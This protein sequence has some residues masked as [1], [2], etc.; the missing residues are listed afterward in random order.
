MKGRTSGKLTTARGH[1]GRT[2]G[3]DDIANLVNEVADRGMA[4]LEK[5]TKQLGDH[6]GGAL[7]KGVRNISDSHK[8]NEKHTKDKFDNLKAPDGD[9]GKRKPDG[10]GPKDPPGGGGGGG[11][12]GRPERRPLDPQPDWHGRSAG[13]MR[14]HRGEALDVRHLSQEE[15]VRV[16]EEESM[17]LANAARDEPRREKGDFPIGKDRLETG[18][19]GSLLHNGVITSHTST[20]KKHG[21]KLPETHPTVADALK[22]AETE[23]ATKG[24]DKGTGHGKCAEVSLISDRLHQLDPDGTRI[25][26]VD[27]AREALKGAM[28]HSR[29]I[30]DIQTRN[31]MIFHG[32]YKPPCTSCAHMLP[33][34]G[35]TA[36]K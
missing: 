26:T 2:R 13:K 29:Q 16:L 22:R 14:H 12:D 19:S 27:D 28:V 33:I 34:L 4:A 30:G 11:G 1:Q 24:L 9:D 31:G 3:K 23:I 5:A 15:R 8:T 18:C 6:L 20:T 7:P 36:H 32:D 21:M 17:T 10:G 25:R 35:V